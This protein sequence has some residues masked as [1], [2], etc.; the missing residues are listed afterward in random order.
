MSSTLEL[1]PTL[2][3]SFAK[4]SLHFG[5]GK[6]L[7]QETEQK[8][9]ERN[10]TYQLDSPHLRIAPSSQILI[11]C[12]CLSIQQAQARKMYLY[13]FAQPAIGRRAVRD[14]VTRFCKIQND[15]FMWPATSKSCKNL[16]GEDILISRVLFVVYGSSCSKEVLGKQPSMEDHSADQTLIL[17][18]IYHNQL[19]S[20]YLRAEQKTFKKCNDKSRLVLT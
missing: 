7:S 19:S 13:C 3:Y 8:V 15:K 10:R 6:F 11:Y 2:K 16:R 20:Q 5:Y 1:V 12:Y 17:R 14:Q 4:F 9:T 18:H